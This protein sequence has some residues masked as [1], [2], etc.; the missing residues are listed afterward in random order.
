MAA[1][2]RS[3]CPRARSTARPSACAARASRASARATR[4]TCT[5]TS[6]W[7]RRCKLTEHQRK[8][9]KEL[10]ES[11]PQGRRAPFA[12]REEL[13]R[14][15]QGP[16]QVTAAR[17][18]GLRRI[19]AAAPPEASSGRVRCARGS[20]RGARRPCRSAGAAAAAHTPCPVMRV[21]KRASLSRPPRISRTRAMTR[22]A[23]SGKCCSSH[24]WNSGFTS[25]GRRSTMLKARLAPAAARRLED[26]LELGLVEE[27]DHRRH[28]HAH[29]HARARQ[30]LDG[31]Q[32]PLRRRGARLQDAR[33]VR[34]QRGDRH[35][36]GDQ[37]LRRHRR[38]QVEVA[39]DQA[40]LVMTENACR[41]SA[42]TSITARVMRSRRSAG[43]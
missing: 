38:D 9:L 11:L 29:R 43:W 8:L 22:A 19:A 17:T 36:D 26:A 32:P 24:C 40:D 6:R 20:A 33:Q 42:S 13:D 39:L 37:A 18:A 12:Q 1:R 21:P 4:A 7:R 2:P 31:A 14:P 23:R 5:A 35:V 3:S 34:V 27:R 16:V 15:R 30:R 25:Q 10:D 28:A 41:H